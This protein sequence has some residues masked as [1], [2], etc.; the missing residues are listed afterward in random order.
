[1]HLR[2]LPN[3]CWKKSCTICDIFMAL[4]TFCLHWDIFWTKSVS[5]IQRIA[6]RRVLFLRY[7]NFTWW[8]MYH[9]FVYQMFFPGNVIIHNDEVSNTEYFQES[10][11]KW[12]SF[13]T[14]NDL[15]CKAGDI[16]YLDFHQLHPDIICR[17]QGK[18]P[19]YL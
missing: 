10:A 1:M 8:H 2:V 12:G 16:I 6:I 13:V 4:R 5:K 7:H 11:Q 3:K 9:F 18:I 19:S 17:F 15:L 14:R